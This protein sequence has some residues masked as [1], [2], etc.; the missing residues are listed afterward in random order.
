MSGITEQI[1]ITAVLETWYPALFR[2]ILKSAAVVNEEV[3]LK[4][5]PLGITV[6]AMNPSHEYM[7]DLFIP[8]TLFHRFDVYEDQLIRLNLKEVLGLVFNRKSG[9][10][11]DSNLRI[12]I[13]G[14]QVTFTGEGQLS[15]KK[16]YNLLEP[17]EEEIPTPRIFFNSKVRI[18]AETLKRIIADC[19]LHE[20]VLITVDPEKVLFQNADGYGRRAENQLDRYADDLLDLDSDGSQVSAYMVEYLAALM[21]VIR[22]LSE[23]VTLELSHCMP[24][25]ITVETPQDLRL[26]YYI[27]PNTDIEHIRD[28]V[29][30]CYTRKKD[31]AA[32]E[33]EEL[34]EVP[35]E[36]PV[37]DVHDDPYDL[38]EELLEEVPEEVVALLRVEGPEEVP[39]P[40]EVDPWILRAA[41]VKYY[42]DNPGVY[43]TPTP[44]QL[45]PYF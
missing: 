37:F 34:E 43:E 15:G 38:E 24:M 39:K 27:A 42:M 26:N 44:E 41:R 29:E 45:R 18:L 19:S 33:P 1:G 11:K 5:D 6:I 28:L 14:A 17:E 21:R 7:I 40:E 22:P 30:G 10:L 12:D 35:E 32:E 23:V 9:K 2:D 31:Q 16:A 13:E 36:V 25:K 20:Y 4:V 8:A 3:D